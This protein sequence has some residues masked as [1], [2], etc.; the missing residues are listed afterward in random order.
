V[1]RAWDILVRIVRQDEQ[2]GQDEAFSQSGAVIPFILSILSRTPSL[3]DT[4][5]V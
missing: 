5:R 3:H 1:V 2:D 4:P